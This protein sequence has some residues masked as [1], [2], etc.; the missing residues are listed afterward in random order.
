MAGTTLRYGSAMSTAT[1]NAASS[2]RRYIASLEPMS[3]TRLAAH[4]ADEVAEHVVAVLA[5]RL[6]RL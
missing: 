2:S 6:E 5:M 1:R 3:S 4:V